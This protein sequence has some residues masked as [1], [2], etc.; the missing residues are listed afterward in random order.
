MLLSSIQLLF[1]QRS[2]HLS[3]FCLEL[4]HHFS[5]QISNIFIYPEI[6]DSTWQNILSPIQS[7]FNKE[8]FRQ[9][10]F[11]L[12]RSSFINPASTYTTIYS[13]IPRFQ[14]K[15]HSFIYTII[16]ILCHLEF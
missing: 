10:S 11:Y 16:I 6:P 14:L 13:P 9:S 5:F 15:M 2:F 12:T 7:L 3:S 1:K 4:F 8:L